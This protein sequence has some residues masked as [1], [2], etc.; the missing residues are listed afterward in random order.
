MVR[1]YPPFIP[2]FA[3]GFYRRLSTTPHLRIGQDVAQVI[4]VPHTDMPLDKRLSDGPGHLCLSLQQLRPHLLEPCSH[5]L[6]S[7]DRHGST[8]LYLGLRNML[9]GF[10]LVD[11]ESR[12]DVPADVHV[13]DI[14]GQDLICGA[15]IEAL[16]QDCFRDVIW[17]DFPARLYARTTSRSWT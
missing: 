8:F 9:V 15:G 6:L 7:G 13:G 10:R 5:P 1:W 14:D 11:L 2:S 16:G 17:M 4:L 12:P 3:D